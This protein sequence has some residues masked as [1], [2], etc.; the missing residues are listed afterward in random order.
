MKLPMRDQGEIIPWW[1]GIAWMRWYD[2]RYVILPFGVHLLA[3]LLRRVW[4]FL[5]QPFPQ[6]EVEHLRAQNKHMKLHESELYR[7]VYSAE[8]DAIKWRRFEL[9]AREKYPDMF[10]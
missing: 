10:E 4:Y 2:G 5:R 9:A 7:R 8:S 6:R 3:G 1:A